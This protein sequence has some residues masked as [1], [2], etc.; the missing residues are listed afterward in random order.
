MVDWSIADCA[1]ANSFF[2]TVLC[3]VKNID[4][5]TYLLLNYLQQILLSYFKKV[6]FSPTVSGYF[7]Y[8]NR[9]KV[10]LM[11]KKQQIKENSNTQM[12]F[13]CEKNHF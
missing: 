7:D 2:E 12:L 1:I 13:W 5:F 10:I 9:S 3:R 4:Y 11:I 6:Y 8:I